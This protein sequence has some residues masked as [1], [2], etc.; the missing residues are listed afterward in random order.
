MAWNP[1]GILLGPCQ[2]FI[3]GLS[4]LL[5]PNFHNTKA[6]EW[7]CTS[8][9][10]KQLPGVRSANHVARLILLVTPY[11]PTP[12]TRDGWFVK[13]SSQPLRLTSLRY[14]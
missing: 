13:G 7:S 6:L 4:Y 14:G 9:C 3:F 11:D 10:R 12:K 2:A 1:H 5:F 8:T